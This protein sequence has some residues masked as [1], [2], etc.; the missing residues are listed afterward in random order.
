MN[1]ALDPMEW[2]LPDHYIIVQQII[3]HI[4][5]YPE[6]QSKSLPNAN[7]LDYY[8]QIRCFNQCSRD[9]NANGRKKYVSFRISVIKLEKSGKFFSVQQHTLVVSLKEKKIITLKSGK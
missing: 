2:N 5:S 7:I 4:L 1:I 3:C 8:K 9:L 6:K